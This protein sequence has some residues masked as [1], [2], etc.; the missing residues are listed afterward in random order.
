[1]KKLLII[2]DKNPLMRQISSEVS[3][4]LSPEDKILLDDMRNYIISS[5]DEEWAQK[6]Q[7]RSGIGLAAVQLGILKRMLVV[8][9]PL[10]DR[11]VDYQLVNPKI[12]ETSVR[13]IALKNGEGCLSVDNE[14]E[15]L[16]H[17][18]F[19]VKIKAFNA[20]TNKEE[21]IIEKGYPAIALQH[22]L[23]HLDGKLF[24]DRIDKN[25]PFI[26]LENEELI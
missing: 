19:K 11:I 23:D 25:K 7:I 15:G 3:L 14:H 21:I 26:P 17:R 22:E 20:L 1:M 4:P 24:Y 12:I 5:Q 9:I 2:K 18:Y 16:V 13:K 8:Y 6:H 10:E